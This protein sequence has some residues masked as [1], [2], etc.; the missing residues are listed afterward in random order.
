MQAPGIYIRT[1]PE[2]AINKVRQRRS[3]YANRMIKTITITNQDLIARIASEAVRC[4]ESAISSMAQK[5][6]LERLTEINTIR[7]IQRRTRV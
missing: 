6:I 5:L 2:H 4:N 3:R 7:E 1:E